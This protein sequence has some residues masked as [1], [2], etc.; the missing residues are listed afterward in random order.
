MKI[1][2]TLL[3]FIISISHS[4][5]QKTDSLQK[6]INNFVAEGNAVTY[7]SV[8]DAPGMKIGEI[9]KTLVGSIASNPLLTSG[10]NSTLDQ[11]EGTFN[12]YNID[13]KKYG[14]KWG[15]VAVWALHPA[16]GGFT[17]QIKDGKYRVIVKGIKTR[18]SKDMIFDMNS[19]FAKNGVIGN[20]KSDTMRRAF[21]A[22][23]MTF[24]EWFTLD[25]KSRGEW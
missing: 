3:I 10:A 13:F 2:L 20:T 18:A 15:N 5:S 24:E 8:H 21:F 19:D 22:L 11:I 16:S 9:K 6:I 14:F 25:E 1:G 17:I 4:F 7:V 12:D 23:G